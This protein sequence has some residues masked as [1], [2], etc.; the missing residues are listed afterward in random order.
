MEAEFAPYG[1]C[2]VCSGVGLGPADGSKR[3]VP[4]TGELDYCKNG[5]V[6]LST[7]AYGAYQAKTIS[8]PPAQ[9]E[10]AKEFAA[11]R[12]EI[13]S[14]RGLILSLSRQV[15]DLKTPNHSRIPPA[16]PYIGWKQ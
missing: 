6:Y 2:P 1:Y 7:L 16:E 9:V 3:E 11:L 14:L 12:D 10:I 15:S 13:A 4:A 5:H 8:Q